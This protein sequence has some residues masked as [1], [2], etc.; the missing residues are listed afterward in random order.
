MQNY[1]LPPRHLSL[2]YPSLSS[3]PLDYH[4]A[5][6]LWWLWGRNHPN[7]AVDRRRSKKHNKNSLNLSWNSSKFL[8]LT[9][10]C[11]PFLLLATCVWFLN[12]A[13]PTPQIKSTNDTQIT[14][15]SIVECVTPLTRTCEVFACGSAT[16][17]VC[18]KTCAN[19]FDESWSRAAMAGFS[20]ITGR[21]G[22]VWG[23]GCKTVNVNVNSAERNLSPSCEQESLK[24][25][26][27]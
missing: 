20:V 6:D 13:I 26:L 8:T 4:F 21:G 12:R 22:E 15:M 23:F 27:R 16:S 9:H 18:S 19:I 24:T 7:R 11:V 25:R 1:L 5:W 10:D 17:C 2:N 14:M 3:R